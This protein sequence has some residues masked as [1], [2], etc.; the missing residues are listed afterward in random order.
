MHLRPLLS[1]SLLPAAIFTQNNLL[2]LLRGLLAAAGQPH[3]YD[4]VKAADS[5]CCCGSVL[6]QTR[7]AC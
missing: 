7:T 5:H 6:Y 2:H 4:G 3:F 1:L